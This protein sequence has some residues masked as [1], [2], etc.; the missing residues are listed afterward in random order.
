MPI[1]SVAFP[2]KRLERTVDAELR[3]TFERVAARGAFRLGVPIDA[4]ALRMPAQVAPTIEIPKEAVRA[5]AAPAPAPTAP[6][7]VA[8]PVSV[9]ATPAPAPPPV[10]IARRAVALGAIGDDSMNYTDWQLGQLAIDPTLLRRAVTRT[11]VAA[12]APTYAPT[13]SYVGGYPVVREEEKADWTTYAMIGAAIL[14]VGGGVYYAKKK[15][16]F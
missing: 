14:V 10:R 15:K 9:T 4:A 5:V 3:E 6:A 8:V 12:P 1:A 2:A 11:A 13:G 7:P 16:M